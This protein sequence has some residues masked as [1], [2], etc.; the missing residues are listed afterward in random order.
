MKKGKCLNF[1]L[2]MSYLGI[3]RLEFWKSYFHIWNQRTRVF[4]NDKFQEK[5]FKSG[6]KEALFRYF[7]ADIW[8][9]LLLYLKSAPSKLSIPSFVQNKKLLIWEQKCL[10]WVF[11]TR[12]FE[13]SCHICNQHPYVFQNANICEKKKKTT[14]NLPCFNI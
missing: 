5:N 6:T 7:W 3:F 9:K 1:W 8:K 2:K 10:I 12:N 13:N 4:Q 11:L 14:Y